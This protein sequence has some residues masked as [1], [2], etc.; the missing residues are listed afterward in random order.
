MVHAIG[1]LAALGQEAATLN[2]KRPLVV[3]DQGI[4][5]AGLL[6][7]ALKPLRAA[8]LD[9]VVYDQVRANPGITLVDAGARYY[10]SERCDGL[11]AIGGGSSIDAAK[12]IGVVVV[13]GGSIAQYEWGKDPIHSRIPP[14]VAVPTTAGTGSEVTLWAVITDPDRKV[15]FNVGGTPNIASW[16]A[17]IDPQLSVNLPAGVTAGTGMDALT[18]AIECYTMAYH[19]PFTD[20]VALHAMEFCGRWLRVAYS[21]GHNLEARYNMSM[22]AM[23][24]GLAYGT[25]SAGAAHAMSQS[26]GGVHDAPHGA[27]TGRLLAPVMEYNYAGEPDRFARIARALGLDTANKTVWKAA[28]VA[29]EYVYQLTEDLDIPSLNELGFAEEEIPMLA[30]KAEEDSQTIGNPRDVDAKN[31]ERIYA[32]AFEAGRHR[33]V[34]RALAH[35]GS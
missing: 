3:T 13:H 26:A 9:P 12:G 31:Y 27:L 16:V 5:K 34:A 24:A 29:V 8:G 10:K 15:K 33:K 19:Q 4:V 22:A 20:A 25:D 1:A 6:E 21:Q 23:L 32:R 17:L 18:H 14:L 28:E 7:E 2:L 30:K 11:V 35:A